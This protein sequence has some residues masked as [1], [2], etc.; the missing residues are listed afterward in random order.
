MQKHQEGAGSMK[1][2]KPNQVSIVAIKRMLDDGPLLAF[3]DIKIAGA[4]E[5]RKCRL[6]QQK[7]M[8]PYLSPPMESWLDE[9]GKRRYY[10]LVVWPS[11]WKEVIQKA[12]LEAWEQHSDG[13]KQIGLADTEFGQ[14]VRQNAGVG[15]QGR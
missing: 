8:R 1:P 4:V 9:T 12:V 5:I 3:V 7:T 13:I 2:L 10:S 11:E 15:G 6:V 14:A